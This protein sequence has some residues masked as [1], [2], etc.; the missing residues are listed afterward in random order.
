MLNLSFVDM[1]KCL[2]PEVDMGEFSA[3]EVDMMS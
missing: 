3:E 2:P 1:E